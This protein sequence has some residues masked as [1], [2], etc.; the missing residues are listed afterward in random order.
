MINHTHNIN[1]T[2]DA[3]VFP[4]KL[5]VCLSYIGIM[6]ILTCI[7]LFKLDS[8]NNRNDKLTNEG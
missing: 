8:N 4:V 1:L 6:M 5:I 7:Y 2:A 3:G